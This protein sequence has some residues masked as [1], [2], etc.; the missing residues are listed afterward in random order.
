MHH[1]HLAEG[2]RLRFPARSVDFDQGVEVGVLAALMSQDVS[3]F[4]RRISKA[5]LGQVRAVAEQFGYRLVEGEAAEDC[6]ELT[7][8]S[9]AARPRLRVVHSGA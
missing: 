7:F 3:E 4:S 5:N 2:L 8:Y 1:I 9:R 6:V